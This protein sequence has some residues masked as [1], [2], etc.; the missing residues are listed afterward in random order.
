MN[1]ELY[2]VAYPEKIPAYSFVTVYCM[3]VTIFSRVIL[4]LF[5]LIFMTLLALIPATPLEQYLTA[6]TECHLPYGI[7]VTCHPTAGAGGRATNYCHVDRRVVS[8]VDH[9]APAAK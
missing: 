7:T 9:C 4:T 1:S 3:N 5:A 8:V 2:V 6:A